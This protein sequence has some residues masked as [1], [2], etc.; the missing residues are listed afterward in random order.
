MNY[1]INTDRTAV[2]S[3]TYYFDDDMS[4]CPRGIKCLL[5]GAG[6]CASLTQYHGEDFWVQWSP[7]P[8]IKRPPSQTSNSAQS[9]RSPRP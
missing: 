1:K 3:T 5:L 6:G 9:P 8:K 2:V 7:L 4:A